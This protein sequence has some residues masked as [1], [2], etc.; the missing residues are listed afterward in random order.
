M[1]TVRES[2]SGQERRKNTETNRE[3]AGWG[4]IGSAMLIARLEEYKQIWSSIPANITG[5][6]IRKAKTMVQNARESFWCVRACVR[7]R[8]RARSRARARQFVRACLR[9]R[10]RFFSKLLY[11]QNNM[12]LGLRPSAWAQ[13]WSTQSLPRAQKTPSHH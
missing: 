2:E 7:A 5:L 13:S 10:V 8:A 3:E 9:A 4:D 6:A 1:N 12:I 11:H